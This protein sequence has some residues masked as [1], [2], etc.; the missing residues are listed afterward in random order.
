MQ[1]VVI[2]LTE[3]K[4]KSILKASQPKEKII[5]IQKQ[6]ETDGDFP[7][8]ESSIKIHRTNTKIKIGNSNFHPN[9]NADVE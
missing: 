2:F 1:R 8:L 4:E 9:H 5:L 3:R 6:K 7:F